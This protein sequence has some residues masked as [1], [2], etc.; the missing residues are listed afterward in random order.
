[1]RELQPMPT[2]ECQESA[3]VEKRGAFNKSQQ[4]FSV[5]VSSVSKSG[6]RNLL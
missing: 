3:E 5:S 2:W 6:E 4:F 1:M